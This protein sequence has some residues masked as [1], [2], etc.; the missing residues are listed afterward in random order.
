MN[1]NK[2]PIQF[3]IGLT[4]KYPTNSKLDNNNFLNELGRYV[5]LNKLNMENENEN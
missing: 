3:I 1:F 2:I 5:R 4:I